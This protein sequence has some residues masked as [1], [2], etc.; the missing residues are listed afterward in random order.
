[1]INESFQSD[2]D[3]L[4]RRHHRGQTLAKVQE[5]RARYERR[6]LGRATVYDRFMGAAERTRSFHSAPRRDTPADP[7]IRVPSCRGKRG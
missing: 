5:L 3:D 1:M 4:Y 6:C 7:P 2:L